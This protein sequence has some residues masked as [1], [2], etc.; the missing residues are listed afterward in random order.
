MD[1]M[2][3]PALHKM[4]PQHYGKPWYFE[5]EWHDISNKFIRQEDLNG[6]SCF[7]IESRKPGKRMSI[8]AHLWVDRETYLIL[9]ETHWAQENESEKTM[10]IRESEL[11]IG[12]CD[13]EN[14]IYGPRVYSQ[15]TYEK[16]DFSTSD[17]KLEDKT[18]VEFTEVKYNVPVQQGDLIMNI[19]TGAKVV[20]YVIGI[21]YTAE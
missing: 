6:R 8:I 4:L 18:K 15:L 13:P 5:H 20:D 21:C 17:P 16:P 10:P 9:K 19:P 7:L 1:P 12:V 2:G 11:Q 14:N 3:D